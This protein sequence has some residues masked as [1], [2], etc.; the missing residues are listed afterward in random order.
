MFAPNK[1]FGQLLKSSSK[2]LVFLK[3]LDSDFL[4]L[5]FVLEI[6]TLSYQR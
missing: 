4:I 5:K 3:T 2:N 1:S 6:K